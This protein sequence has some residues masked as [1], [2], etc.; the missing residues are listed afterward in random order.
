MFVHA[1]DVIATDLQR[2]MILLDARNGEM[3]ALNE[4]GRY[5][6]WRLPARSAVALAQDVAAVFNVDADCACGDVLWFLLS[7]KR[8]GLIEIVP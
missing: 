8:A 6:W 2:E 1:T 5:I 3:F 4:T 7:L